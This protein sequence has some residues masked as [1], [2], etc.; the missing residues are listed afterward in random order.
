MY[1]CEHTPVKD[2][3]PQEKQS[4]HLVRMERSDAPED[5]RKGHNSAMNVS[6]QPATQRAHRE[7]HASDGQG[8]GITFTNYS[9]SVSNFITTQKLRIL[10]VRT[11]H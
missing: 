2:L 5:L 4:R 3:R 9:L 6:T 11:N 10:K 7:K 1:N 8:R